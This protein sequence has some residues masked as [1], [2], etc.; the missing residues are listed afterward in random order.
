[1]GRYEFADAASVNVAGARELSTVRGLYDEREAILKGARV[2]RDCSR[3]DTLSPGKLA[4]ENF[5][6]TRCTDCWAWARTL[7]TRRRL[8]HRSR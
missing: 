3:R 4:D 7:A 1:M 8:E 5:I 2:C 6:S